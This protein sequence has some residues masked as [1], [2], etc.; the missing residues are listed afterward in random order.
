MSTFPFFKKDPEPSEE[1]D[2]DE[3]EDEDNDKKSRV[4]YREEDAR[5]HG[6]PQN[7][8]ALGNSVFFT[9]IFLVNVCQS[10][11]QNYT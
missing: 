2:N 5:K 4:R 8:S 1:E 7:Q 9:K 6:F 10:I 3:E 11:L